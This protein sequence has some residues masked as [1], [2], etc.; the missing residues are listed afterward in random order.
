ML[1]VVVIERADAE[2]L[3]DE[4]RRLILSLR[5]VERLTH[6]ATDDLSRTIYAEIRAALG[7]A[8][9]VTGGLAEALA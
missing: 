6:N 7:H 3:D 1:D 9:W 4:A 2:V 5:N 8:R